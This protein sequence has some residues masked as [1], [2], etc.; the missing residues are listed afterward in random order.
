MRPFAHKSNKNSKCTYW[1]E[2][3][4]NCDNNENIR[5][6]FRI[7]GALFTFLQ[8]F[9]MLPFLNGATIYLELTKWVFENKKVRE[10][11]CSGVR[12]NAGAP[13]KVKISFLTDVLFMVVKSGAMEIKYQE[14]K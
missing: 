6:A 1:I 10:P 11:P 8:V 13:L 12:E 5:L 14:K 4:E 9:D 2:K 3:N 7:E